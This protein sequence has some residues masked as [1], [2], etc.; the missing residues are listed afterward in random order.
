VADFA[1]WSIATLDELGYWIGYNP[2]SMVVRS[3]AIVLE[4]NV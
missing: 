3:G 2:C 4:R 1:V